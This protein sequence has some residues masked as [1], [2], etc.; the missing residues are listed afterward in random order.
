MRA[1]KKNKNNLNNDSKRR[2]TNL[3]KKSKKR[4]NN[5]SWEKLMNK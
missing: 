5:K 4:K 3:K 2:K 1:N